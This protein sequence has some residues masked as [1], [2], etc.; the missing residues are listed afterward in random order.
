[1]SKSLV[2]FDIEVYKDYFLIA[3]KNIETGSVKCFE[4]YD[5]VELD[6][7]GIR[8]IV[9]KN[10]IVS[11]N[12]INFD[13][14]LMTYALNGATNV[15]LKKLCDSIIVKSYKYWDC[16]REFG[17]VIS[18]KI[19]HIDLFEVAP[20]KASLKAYGGKMHSRTLQDLP[21][22][23]S[24][25]I[26]PEQRAPMREYCI[27]DL[28][29]TIDL[30]K[31]LKPQIDLRS[32]L[33]ARYDV[34]LRSRSDAQMAED[35]I[36]K[37]L[38]KL[39]KCKV[40]KSS[41][42]PKPFRYK[43]PK[44]IRFQSES[45][46]QILRT[47]ESAT[48]VVSETGKVIMPDEIAKAFVSI[49]RSSYTLG[50]GGI[51]S[52]ESSVSYQ[53]G[54]GWV[55][56]DRDVAS[57]YP[58]IILNDGLYPETLGRQFLTA[59]KDIVDRRIAAKNSGDKV[60]ADCL[61]ITING[62]FGKFGSKYSVLFSPNLLIQTTMTGQ[63]ALLMLIEML[64]LE[65][66]NVVSANTDG[67]VIHHHLE[68]AND[69][70]N[71]IAG[72]ES[73]TGFAVEDTNYSAIYFKDVNNYIALKENGYKLKGIY[74]PPTPVANSWPN[75]HN[76]ICVDAIIKYLQD[77]TP[78]EDTIMACQDIRRFVSVRTVKGGAVKD[79]VYLGRVARWYYSCMVSGPITYKINGYT[80]PRTEGAQP[81]MTLPDKLPDD[82]DYEFYMAECLS[83]LKDIG[84]A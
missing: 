21:I 46:R 77:G 9:S 32:E 22:D 20:G 27:N 13:I 5:G 73:V 60:T 74:A 62:S 78:L 28:Q 75:P 42:I 67:I 59:Y 64:H 25:N 68:Y 23:P 12:G 10:T 84:Y 3:F 55:L 24:A 16:E 33:G 11:F 69:V 19:D 57:Y 6:T 66:F 38:E 79:D 47:V 70:D 29:T 34:D 63:L 40:E 44:F 80:V 58:T 50:I 45:M 56:S 71:I 2:A 31:Q 15:Q 76:Q 65:G 49:G 61:K 52:T 7:D 39:T 82:I 37:E 14:P 4:M 43:A 18:K 53:A 83:I 35:V 72:W 48:F 8:A 51:H 1:M 17:F 41:A 26:L 36:K 54:D 30:Y 81:C